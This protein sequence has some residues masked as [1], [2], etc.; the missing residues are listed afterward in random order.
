MNYKMLATLLCLTACSTA[1]SHSRASAPV[2]ATCPTPTYEVHFSPRGGCAKLVVDHIAS[3]SKYVHVQTYSFTS[4]PITDAL[5]AAR[6]RGVNV[7][8]LADRSDNSG[9]SL[10]KL[11][12][13]KKAGVSVYLD[14]K[15][16]IAHNKVMIVDDKRVETGSYNYTNQAEAGNA[17]NCLLITDATLTAAYES[18][19]QVHKAH[20]TPF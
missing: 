10:D 8:V 2:R 11:L 1:S 17:E 5:V 19:W 13:L 20:S 4:Q 12:Q 3:S 6:R 16:P 14:S 9:S 15:H 7:E 18:N